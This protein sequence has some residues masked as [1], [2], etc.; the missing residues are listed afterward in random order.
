[1]HEGETT[2]P[3]VLLHFNLAHEMGGGSHSCGSLIPGIFLYCRLTHT[4]THN[5]AHSR[6]HTRAAPGF[7][8]APINILSAWERRADPNKGIWQCF[9]SNLKPTIES[10]CRWNATWK[11]FFPE[12]RSL[13]NARLLE[14]LSLSLTSG[15]WPP[16]SFPHTPRA[17]YW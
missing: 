7:S 12:T 4:R 9:F 1:M 2:S 5:H 8:I 3:C 17:N 15:V 10:L 6:T 11:G 14:M 13:W 16:H